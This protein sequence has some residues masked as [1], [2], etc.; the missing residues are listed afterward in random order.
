[1]AHYSWKTPFIRLGLLGF[2]AGD[3]HRVR[4]LDGRFFWIAAGRAWNG[5][6]RYRYS[7]IGEGCLCNTLHRL[8]KR[9]AIGIGLVVNSAIC[10]ILLLLRDR[11]WSDL[12]QCLHR[13]VC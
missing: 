4:H 8:G 11:F 13:A 6:N 3:Q 2:L 9:L 1:M 7:R 10:L 5:I 12:G